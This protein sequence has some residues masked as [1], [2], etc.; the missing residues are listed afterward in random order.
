MKSSSPKSNMNQVNSGLQCNELNKNISDAD[1]LSGNGVN[2]TLVDAVTN[3]NSDSGLGVDSSCDSGQISINSWG[4]ISQENSVGSPKAGDID[5]IQTKLS[6]IIGTVVT[7]DSGL[8]LDIEEQF[9]SIDI[10]KN[11]LSDVHI[12]E[13]VCNRCNRSSVDNVAKVL[14]NAEYI[15][16]LCS[17]I[18]NQISP[19]DCMN[20]VNEAFTPDEDGNTRLHLAV[21]HARLDIIFTLIYLVPHPSYLDVQNQLLQT[22][23]HLAVLTGQPRVVRRLVLAGASPSIRDRHGN[24]PLHLACERGELECVKELT[25]PVTSMEMKYLQLMNSAVYQCLPKICIP[26]D[27]EFYNYEGKTCVHI[28]TLNQHTDILLW[29]KQFGANINAQEFKGGRTPLTFAV[30]ARN[31]NLVE[32][33]VEECEANVNVKNYAGLSPFQIAYGVDHKIASQLE[34]LGAFPSYH[35]FSDSDSDLECMDTSDENSDFSDYEINGQ[36]LEYL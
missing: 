3:I 17:R 14:R 5:N 27:L 4:K 34:S 1:G 11:Q 18:I 25:R 13:T 32:F 10:S 36:S 24:T 7:S 9:E 29:L 22:T 35:C 8:E 33:L 12:D 19:Q 26:P 31:A 28:A 15:S 23:L 20:L 21:I 16:K 6:E 30:E 2:C